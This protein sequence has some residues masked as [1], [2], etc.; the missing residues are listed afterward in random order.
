[1]PRQARPAN[2]MRIEPVQQI[3]QENHENTRRLKVAAYCRVS[4]E[5]EEQQSSYEIQVEYYTNTIQDN[6]EWKFA[7]IYADEGISGTS[8]RKRDDFNR[9]I[10]DC[11]AGRIDMIITKSISRFARN[12]LDCLAHVRMLK[13]KG[14]AVFF[15][16]ENLNTMD[17]SGEMVLTILS[18]LA[19]EESRSISTNVHWGIVRRYE[20]GVV[21]VNTKRFLGYTKN[22]DQE[23]IIEIEE[24]I[25]VRRIFRYTLE[26]YGSEWIKNKM[27][28][29]GFETGAGKTKWWASVV[30]RI[31]DNEKYMGDALLQK[32]YTEDFLTKK[33]VKN[34]GQ[35]QQ[36]YVSECIDPIIPKKIFYKVR[37]EK[38]IRRSYNEM[39]RSKSSTKTSGKHQTKY[40][41]ADIMVC[42]EC[43][44][45]F[46]RVI[47]TNRQG[48]K[49][50]VWRC[51]SR[52]ENGT[53][54]CHGSPTILE[55][56]I[57][58]S[59]MRTLGKIL[60]AGDEQDEIL[61][62]QM[63]DNVAV[64]YEAYS[65]EELDRILAGLTARL[66]YYRGQK[67]ADGELDI[68]RLQ[69]KMQIIEDEIKRISEAYEKI[70]IYHRC[71]D[72]IR[73]TGKAQVQVAKFRDY[74]EG[75]VRRMIQKIEVK[76]KEKYKMILK[77][78]QIMEVSMEEEYIREATM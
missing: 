32:T 18:S 13:E 62:E 3:H 49:I 48:Q 21:R 15:E 29:D 47:W 56:D 76:T 73:N 72:E 2:V 27:E 58:R 63:L 12:T 66:E 53:K 6:P 46:R 4:T 55:K 50:P 40:A 69:K 34:V 26:G 37:E 60:P 31:T 54:Y 68:G 42:A 22:Q 61:K 39:K 23:I 77:S 20:K 71:R 24:A 45:F 67:M 7:G 17:P 11:K 41:L 35:L 52:L 65:Y 25:A 74:D 10:R 57:Q 19:Q 9:M 8:T 36:F 43:G 16:K 51:I 28:Q 44:H 78:G 70:R 75:M 33:R 5:E 30:D 38:G 1:M 14:I 64:F 59:I